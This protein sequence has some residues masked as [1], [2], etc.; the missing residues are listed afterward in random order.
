MWCWKH[1]GFMIAFTCILMRNISILDKLCRIYF[2][3][4]KRSVLTFQLIF[5]TCF[6]SCFRIKVTNSTF[7][8]AS[9]N[10]TQ[11]ISSYTRNITVISQS[12]SKPTSIFICLQMAAYIFWHIFRISQYP[13]L[14]QVPLGS[15]C[16]ICIINII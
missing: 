14:R 8:S 16:G 7:I 13:Q 4:S 6:I 9:Y 11:Q 10:R 5:Q 3:C 1:K 15:P 2:S 12:I